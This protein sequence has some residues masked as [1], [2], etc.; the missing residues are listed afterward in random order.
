M[1]NH[2]SA[3]LITAGRFLS[4]KKLRL[5]KFGRENLTTKIRNIYVVRQ[6]DVIER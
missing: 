2:S 4:L 3:Y 1:T 6:N 5:F